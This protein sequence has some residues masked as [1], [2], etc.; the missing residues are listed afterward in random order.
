M[1]GLI[2]EELLGTIKKKRFIIL[3]ALTLIGVVITLI[4]ARSGVWNDLTYLFA[5]QGYLSKVFI[6]A[7][8]VTVILSVYRRKYTRSSILQTE[9]RNQKRSSGVLAR[10]IAG[11]VLI[12]ACFLIYA[13]LFVLL[14]LISGAHNPAAQTGQ[15]MIYLSLY[16]L[17]CLAAYSIALFWLYLTAFPAVPVIVYLISM[18]AVPVLFAS[19]GLYKTNFMLPACF[20]IPALAADNEITHLMYSDPNAAC[21]IALVLQ[22]IIPLLLAIFV[23]KLKKL[24]EENP[25]PKTTDETEVSSV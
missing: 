15:F 11:Y 13:L 23:F 7:V 14:G 21:F 4:D 6:H 19:T 18:A 9:A 3:T 10:A 17:A 1:S 25:E 22:I 8:T 24:K 16:C 12:I 5:M 2:K 20:V